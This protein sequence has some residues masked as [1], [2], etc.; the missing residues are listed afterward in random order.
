[1]TTSFENYKDDATY[2]RYREMHADVKD[3]EHNFLNTL[4]HFQQMGL[5]IFERNQSHIKKLE[6]QL[7]DQKEVNKVLEVSIAN[8]TAL[9]QRVEELEQKLQET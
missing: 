1:M 4:V 9:R 5:Q 7:K 6:S 3:R 2:E 8:E